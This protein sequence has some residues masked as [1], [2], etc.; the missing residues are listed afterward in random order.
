MLKT[1]RHFK[2]ISFN[3]IN[4]IKNDFEGKIPHA[5]IDNKE[6]YNKINIDKKHNLKKSKNSI[7]LT[8]NKYIN[9][10]LA[11]DYKNILN[12]NTM[13]NTKQDLIFHNDISINDFQLLAVIGKGSFGKVMLAK[14]LLDNKY[15]ALKIM[16][17][18]FLCEKNQIIHVNDECLILRSINN[19]F[20]VN[21]K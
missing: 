21:F 11:V 4:S 12:N 15:Y 10:N 6:L 7:K 14:F 9:D 16:K 5:N 8:I 18:D 3:K 1:N 20:I 2:S 13:I 17:K 19:P